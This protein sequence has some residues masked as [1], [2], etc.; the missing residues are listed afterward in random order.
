MSL[1][2][3]YGNDINTARGNFFALS[4]GW[5][6]YIGHLFASFRY[7]N[8]IVQDWTWST[9]ETTLLY[10]ANANYTTHLENNP[11]YHNSFIPRG[12]FHDLIDGFNVNEPWDRIDGFT[13]N[14]V[15]QKFGGF[16]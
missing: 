13:T 4:E 15:Y 7:N 11:T 3:G 1:P 2:G 6:D 14:D 12:I 16:L 5:A 8:T 9:D 10:N